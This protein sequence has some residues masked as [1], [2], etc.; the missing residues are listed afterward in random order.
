MLNKKCWV[1]TLIG[2]IIS[3][4]AAIVAGVLITAAGYRWLRYFVIAIW[5][6]TALSLLGAT[7]SAI[8]NVYYENRKFAKMLSEHILLLIIGAV[9]AVIATAVLTLIIRM[10]TVTVVTLKILTAVS[11][12]AAGLVM[13]ADLC[14]VYGLI[15]GCRNRALIVAPPA[16]EDVRARKP[17]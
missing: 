2:F 12:F 6:L 4:V 10:G 9:S 1:C 8:I 3:V 14:F 13:T 5:I 7:I 15:T 17:E 16:C 11:A